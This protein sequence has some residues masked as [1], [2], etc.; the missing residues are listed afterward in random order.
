MKT[1]L[2]RRAAL[3]NLIHLRKQQELG[4]EEVTA[5]SYPESKSGAAPC[6]KI[7]R[8]QGGPTRGR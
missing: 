4:F 6:R 3:A 7:V 8:L 2:H 5:H 1:G